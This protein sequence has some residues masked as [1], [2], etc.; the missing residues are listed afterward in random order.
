MKKLT[1]ADKSPQMLKRCHSLKKSQIK[2][3]SL[4]NTCQC[5]HRDT[6]PKSSCPGKENFIMIHNYSNIQF[7]KSI[8]ITK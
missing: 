7:S 8:E 6:A 3:T 2:L 4:A 1:V 5:W